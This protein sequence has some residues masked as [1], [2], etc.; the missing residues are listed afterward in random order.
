MISSCVCWHAS[1]T[2][3]NAWLQAART[4][5]A[6]LGGPK[7]CQGFLSPGNIFYPK[8]GTTS[9]STVAS[10]CR[11]CTPSITFRWTNGDFYVALGSSMGL[12]FLVWVGG[13]LLKRVLYFLGNEP[14]SGRKSPILHLPHSQLANY[15]VTNCR[16]TY[17]PVLSFNLS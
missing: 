14:S 16:F 2:N 6:H 8:K 17:N 10:R 9:T 3:D 7:T 12:A 1:V 5:S 11:D 15:E 13:G 4:F